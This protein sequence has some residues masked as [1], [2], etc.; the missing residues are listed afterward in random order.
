MLGGMA[1]HHETVTIA[2]AARLASVSLQQADPDAAKTSFGG[3]PP[4]A[5]RLVQYPVQFGLGR[6]GYDPTD[7]LRRHTFYPIAGNPLEIMSCKEFAPAEPIRVVAY[8]GERVTKG[9]RKSA[10]Y[11]IGLSLRS[12]PKHEVERRHAGSQIGYSGGLVAI[13]RK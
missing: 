2:L 7:I 5:H 4:I 1:Q 12:R 8:I 10:K 9:V 3:D 11:R 13:Y 6:V